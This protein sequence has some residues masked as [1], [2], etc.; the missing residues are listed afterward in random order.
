MKHPCPDPL[1]ASVVAGTKYSI[2]DDK[3]T[4]S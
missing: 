3:K 1:A 2:V 4:E